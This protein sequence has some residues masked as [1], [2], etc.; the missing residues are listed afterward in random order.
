MTRGLRYNALAAPDSA[1]EHRRRV[2]LALFLALFSVILAL[3]LRFTALETYLQLGW[4]D[5]VSTFR[6]VW[7]TQDGGTGFSL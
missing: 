1:L 3:F 5:G 2:I 6:A 7:L 4:Q